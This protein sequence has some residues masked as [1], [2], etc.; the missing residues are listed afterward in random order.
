MGTVGYMS[1]EQVRGEPATAA[2][3]QFSLGCVL[4]EMLTGRPPFERSSKAET[5]SAILRDDPPP[6]EEKNPKVPAPVRWVVERCLA[7]PPRE[8]Y[9]LTR[10]IAGAL[11]TL[12]EH[13]RELS[14]GTSGVRRPRRPGR[15]LRLGVAVALAAAGVAVGAIVGARLLSSRRAAFELPAFHRLTWRY[16]TVLS[17]RF[18]PD[19][20]TVVY[21]ASWEGMAPAIYLKRPE[22]PD[23][24]PVDLPEAKLL[25]ISSSGEMA[26]QLNER[27][28]HYEVTRGTLAR[29]AL[30][31]GTPREIAEDI[32]HADWGPDGRLVVARD[33]NGK[34]RLEYPLGKVLYETAGHVSFPRL[35]PGKDLIAFVDNPLKVDDRGSIAV[36]DLQGQKRTL[37]KEFASVQG[38]AWSPTG[39]EVWF[40]AAAAGISRSLWGVALSGRQRAIARVPGDLRLQDVT[41]TGRVLLTRGDP[42]YWIRWLEPGRTRERDLSWFGWSSPADL[43]PD[44]KTM[45]FLEAGEPTGANYAVCLRR[46]GGPPVRLGEGNA[47]ALSPDGKWV[48]SKLPK[49]GAP[50]VLLPTGTGE[51]REIRSEG[52]SVNLGS[53]SWSAWLPDGNRLVLAGREG[54]HGLDRLFIQDLDTGKPRPISPEGVGGAFAVSPDGRLVAAEGPDGK[55]VLYP[56]AGGQ[57]RPVQGA[58][59]GDLPLQWSADGLSLYVRPPVELYSPARVFRLDL[60]T[61]NRTLW[62]EL[63][64]EDSAGVVGTDVIRLTPDGRSYA[65]SYLRVLSDLYLVDGLK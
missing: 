56:V 21:S 39:S 65:Y 64:P 63:F 34:G 3:D 47:G 6:I 12:S 48:I 30:T 25:A 29:V 7:K 60:K 45:V 22:G 24:V 40:T 43:S 38:L 62:K 15:V 1:P 50:I 14:S 35:S 52:L 42:R 17:A 49:A 51:P 31:G 4:Y 53:R 8:R 16:G 55:I 18:A 41:P 5:L 57:S 61:G 36:V 37:S 23:A 13:V 19:E 54:K 28:A 26:I 44:G 2:S 27:Y 10:E 59:E 11:A 46:A 9:P 33:V 20:Q 58:A 32:N